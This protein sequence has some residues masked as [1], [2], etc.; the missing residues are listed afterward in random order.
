M[1]QEKPFSTGCTDALVKGKRRSI[2]QLYLKHT[3][4]PRVRSL[5]HRM[6]RRTVSAYH[7]SSSV[8]EPQR[9]SDVGGAPDEPILLKSRRRFIRRSTFQRAVCQRLAECL[10]LF[11]P[12]PL[13]HLRLLDCAEVQES[14]RHLEDHIQSIKC[15]IAHP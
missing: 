9:L 7:Q 8:R 2:R 12:P 15:I 14:A 6:N 10:G 11:I 13:T 1:R 5:Q 4:P 3:V